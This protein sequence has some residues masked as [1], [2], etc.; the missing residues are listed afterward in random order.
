[1]KPW[2]I[3]IQYSISVWSTRGRPNNMWRLSLSNTEHTETHTWLYHSFLSKNIRCRLSSMFHVKVRC[4]SMCSELYLL[5]LWDSAESLDYFHSETRTQQSE[6][7]WLFWWCYHVV[8]CVVL[9]TSAGHVQPSVCVGSR[10]MRGHWLGWLCSWGW[11][12]LWGGESSR[13]F[14]LPWVPLFWDGVISRRSASTTERRQLWC[15]T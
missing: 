1:M 9:C 10:L 8:D 11:W 5:H 3:R 15:L 14:R 6:F 13:W 7:D 4:Q 12:G 2:W